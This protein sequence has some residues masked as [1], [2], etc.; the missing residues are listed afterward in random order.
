MKKILLYAALTLWASPIISNPIV[1]PVILPNELVFVEGEWTLELGY[2]FADQEEYP[3]VSILLSSSSGETE[4][5]SFEITEEEGFIIVQDNENLSD[6]FALNV[7][8]DLIEVTW[9]IDMWGYIEYMTSELIFGEYPNAGVMKPYPG[10]SISYINYTYSKDNSPTIGQT[11]DST[12]AMGTLTGIV[13]DNQLQ[14]VPE[15][16]FVLDQWFTTTFE[17]EYTIRVLSNVFSENEIL[18][19]IPSIGWEN[20]AAEINYIMEPDS[21]VN[22]DIYLLDDLTVGITE[23]SGSGK[24]IF[25][26]YPNPAIQQLSINYDI[27]MPGH[28]PTLAIEIKTMAALQIEI[29]QVSQGKGVFQL[30]EQIAPGIYIVSLLSGQTVLSS[31]RLVINH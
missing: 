9:G 29:Y 2:F 3:V 22:F 16:T 4:L 24:N 1:L 15:Q 14:P 17:G 19:L 13:F 11:N 23:P 18:H 26:F 8:G 7:E 30:P 21:V 28:A 27:N 5:L 20:I 25:R 10:Q 12:G 6:P 31:G